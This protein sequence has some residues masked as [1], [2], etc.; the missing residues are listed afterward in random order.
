MHTVAIFSR[1]HLHRRGSSLPPI[2][3]DDEERVM[4]E[5]ETVG[6]KKGTDDDN[7]KDGL[8]DREGKKSSTPVPWEQKNPKS[9]EAITEEGSSYTST[10]GKQEQLS[11]TTSP[12][13][14]PPPPVD[15][16]SFKPGPESS[17]HNPSVND[18]TKTPIHDDAATAPTAPNLFDPLPTYDWTAFTARYEAQLERLHQQEVGLMEEFEAWVS[19]RF[20]PS[21]SLSFSSFRELI[22]L[23]S[24]SPT[25]RTYSNFTQH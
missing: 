22:V 21:L 8:G 12:Y 1:R 19:V 10:V 15:H 5:D 7:K 14:A 24:P 25:E 9:L 3:R 23:V 17:R 6:G 16:S 2:N 11:S 13:I 4:D 18:L 20:S